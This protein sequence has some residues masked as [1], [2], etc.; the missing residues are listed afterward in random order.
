MYTKRGLTKFQVYVTPE[1]PRTYFAFKSRDL[2]TLLRT[3]RG[4]MRRDYG[5]LLG[6]RTRIRIY[7]DGL[8]KVL[9]DSRRENENE[10]GPQRQGQGSGKENAEG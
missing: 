5:V 4:R 10:L 6:K 3:L 7:N 9:Y 1:A 8:D 2:E